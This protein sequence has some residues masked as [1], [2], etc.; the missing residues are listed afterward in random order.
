MDRNAMLLLIAAGQAFRVGDSIV[1]A[2][3]LMDKEYGEGA[4]RCSSCGTVLNLGNQFCTAYMCGLPLIGP[5]GFPRWEI[6][7]QLA[8]PER[9]QKVEKIFRHPTHG[10]YSK[11][12]ITPIPLTVGEAEQL[13]KELN[14][15]EASEFRFVHRK[16]NPHDIVRRYSLNE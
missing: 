8:K 3:Q 15:E 4:T 5:F 14:A 11:F 16:M 12:Y 9:Q 13:T 7:N 1:F 6:W 10:R 2:V